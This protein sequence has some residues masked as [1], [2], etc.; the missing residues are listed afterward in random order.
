MITRPLFVA[1]PTIRAPPAGCCEGDLPSRSEGGRPRAR[2][3]GRRPPPLPSGCQLGG[4][5]THCFTL[6]ASCLTGHRPRPPSPPP[7]PQTSVHN[8]GGWTTRRLRPPPH[9]SCCQ[10]FRRPAGGLGAPP[11]VR[12]LQRG[13]G[14][15]TLAAAAAVRKKRKRRRAGHP[16]A[17]GSTPRC[18]GTFS[19]PRFPFFYATLCVNGGPA[20]WGRPH[21]SP[22]ARERLDERRGVT[23]RCPAAGARVRRPPAGR[24]PCR[25][26]PIT[27]RG[28]AHG[29]G[30]QPRLQTHHPSADT[31]PIHGTEEGG[32]AGP[33][34]SPC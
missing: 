28:G 22:G 27:G 1:Q 18:N 17:G 14:C 11:T 24:P 23:P 13:S 33:R 4:P 16:P 7:P 34:L 5:P 6:L 3:A 25:V 10:K 19:Q 29:V 12:P 26:G 9:P 31:H 15:K 20:A 21:A 8:G 2:H 30:R 32:M